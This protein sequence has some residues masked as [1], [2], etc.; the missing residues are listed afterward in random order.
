MTLDHW[1]YRLL[2]WAFGYN[3]EGKK[4]C[5]YND[6][7]YYEELPKF[8][9]THY[10]PLFHLTNI[11][12]ILLPF[13]F[14]GKIVG[15]LGR[16]AW[17]LILRLVKNIDIFNK[18]CERFWA[19]RAKF[20]KRAKKQVE[21]QEKRARFKDPWKLIYKYLN[22]IHD[23][24]NFDWFWHHYNDKFSQSK[25]EILEIWDKIRKNIIKLKEQRAA[26]KEAIRQN[27]IFWTN[28]SSTLLKWFFNIFYA[29]LFIVVGLAFI[30]YGSTLA[31]GFLACIAWC[32]IHLMT[33]EW[34]L[35]IK[36]IVGGIFGLCLLVTIIY[37]LYKS[38]KSFNKQIKHSTILLPVALIVGISV[39]FCKKVT[40][41]LLNIKE[42]FSMFYEEN[43]PPI[44]I[45]EREE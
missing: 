18:F 26:R 38:W 12:L 45:I 6:S 13:V 9:Y 39:A 14:I 7:E 21:K 33:F 43:C 2:H 42:F 40:N 23:Y 19:K 32:L 28:L 35:A 16:F 37:S 1:R 15:R 8:L 41:V 34:I 27:I 11:I 20:L 44:T 22:N 36:W 4:K 30:L 3:K 25:D 17:Y 5:Y 24:D 10:C 31:A 29:C